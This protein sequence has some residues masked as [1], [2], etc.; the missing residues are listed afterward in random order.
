MMFMVLIAGLTNVLCDNNGVVR[1]T[2]IS[3][4]TL[5]N[6]IGYEIVRESVA[7]GIMRVARGYLDELGGCIYKVGTLFKE[8]GKDWADILGLL[9]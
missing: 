7:D 3:G 4:S 5:H 9:I 1:N 2:S 8:A 6:S